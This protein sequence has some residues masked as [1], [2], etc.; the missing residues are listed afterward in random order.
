MKLSLPKVK[1]W[2]VCS[3]SLY[4]VKTSLLKMGNVIDVQETLIGFRR[5]EFKSDGFYLN[6]RR[7][8]I[9]GIN[10]HQSYPYI[11]YAMPGSIQRLDAD[12]LK[13]ELA[14]NAVRTAHCPQ[15]H[16]FIQRCSELGLLVFTEIPGWG[17]PKD[18]SWKMQALQNAVHDI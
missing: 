7:L 11:G 9:R 1:V 10:R 8:K 12:I 15:S 14:M 18:D 16:H 5:A 6:G 2:D 4:I 3:P 17:K 13:N